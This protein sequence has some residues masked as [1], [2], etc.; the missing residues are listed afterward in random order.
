MMTER[1]TI[2]IVPPDGGAG[3]LSVEDAMS[4][5]LD[6][7]RLLNIGATH[8]SWRLVSASTNSPL[9]IVAEAENE[10]IGS[11]QKRAFAESMQELA[12]GKFP[13]AWRRPELEEIAVG[14]LSRTRS[15]SSVKVDIGKGVA[16]ILIGAGDG[17]DLNVFA[18]T[19]LLPAPQISRNTKTQVGSIDGTLLQVTTYYSKPAIRLRERKTNREIICVIPPHLVEA[20]SGTASVRDVWAHRRL[21]V[22]GRIVY[23]AYGSIQRVDATGLTISDAPPGALPPLHDPD[24]TGGMSAAEYLERFRAGELG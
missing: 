8:T 18:D 11:Y 9:T 21:T 15:T 20:F 19:F 13:E 12:S 2:T 17:I 1:L 6:T 10:V 4:Q 22:R 24:F 3:E 7:I 14:L 16:P 23:G 5:V